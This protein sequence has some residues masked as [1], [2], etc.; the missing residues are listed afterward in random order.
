MPQRAVQISLEKQ[1][2]PLGPIASRGGGGG[3]SVPVFIEKPITVCD[4]TWMV[5]TPCPLYGIHGNENLNK[6]AHQYIAQ[7]KAAHVHTRDV[8]Y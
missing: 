6:N 2:D 5:R 8:H 7:C 4:F 1:L 3:G